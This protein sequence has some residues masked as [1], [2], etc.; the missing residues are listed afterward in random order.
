MREEQPN[1]HSHSCARSHALS[2]TLAQEEEGISSLTR[3]KREHSC[4]HARATA[5]TFVLGCECGLK[6]NTTYLTPVK[7][8]LA[9][10]VVPPNI[11][12]LVPEPARLLQLLHTNHKIS[13]RPDTQTER[14]M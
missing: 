9:P 5:Q 11:V 8:L 6:A 14:N 12:P 1:A 10:S 7:C 13:A 2:L 4:R 3:A